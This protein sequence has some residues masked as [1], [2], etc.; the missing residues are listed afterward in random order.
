MGETAHAPRWRDGAG[1][2]SGT[3]TSKGL[4]MDMQNEHGDKDRYAVIESTLH[5][6]GCKE[7]RY[8]VRSKRCTIRRS[9]R[10]WSRISK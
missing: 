3:V 4:T 2:R 5:T 1:G 6:Y 10:C 7:T 9:T 8:P